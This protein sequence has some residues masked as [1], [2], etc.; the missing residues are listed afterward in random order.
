MSLTKNQKQMIML[1]G[2][3]ATIVVVLGIFFFSPETFI[4]TPYAPP[5]VDTEIPV[6]VLEHPEYRQLRLPPKLELP[7]VPGRMGRD[8]PFEPY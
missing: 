6:T 1:G 3:L 8:N 4:E 2:I 5:I 7:L